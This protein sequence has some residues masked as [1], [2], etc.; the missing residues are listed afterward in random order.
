MAKSGN[1]FF[2]VDFSEIFDPRKFSE[3]FDPQKFGESFKLPGVESQALLATQQK[4]L[5]AMTQANRIAFEGMQ[6]VAQRQVEIMREA[7]E[8]TSRSLNAIADAKSPEERFTKQVDVAKQ[9]FEKALA[10]LREIAEMNAKSNAEA[11][12]L[13]NKRLS[14]TMEEFKKAFAASAPKTRSK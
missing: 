10:N 3:M 9:T 7:M 1:P 4:N 11:M 6:A 5:E 8:E 13:I 12:E 14:E 2:D